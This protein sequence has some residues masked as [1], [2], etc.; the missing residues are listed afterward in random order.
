MIIG[1]GGVSRSGKTTLAN[2]L[3]PFFKGKLTGILHQDEYVMAGYSAP[4]INGI[5]DW[6]HPGSIDFN[7]LKHDLLWMKGHLDVVIL[8][9]LFAFSDP[10]LVSN[11]D[12][13]IYIDLD[14]NTFYERK[15]LDSRWGKVPEWYLEHIWKS[16]IK[17]GLPSDDIDCF[18]L[19]GTSF[20]NL[21]SV[22]L[23][24]DVPVD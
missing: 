13:K 8:E 6:E 16:H 11:Y 17:F 7:R 22:L 24:L 10:D 1:I 5:F 14:Y 23:Y 21:K 3:V 4:L 19:N 15:K 2:R 9:G 12:K 18:R 20:D